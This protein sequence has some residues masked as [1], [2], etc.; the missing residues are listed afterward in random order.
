MLWRGF[1]C[2][3]AV[4]LLTALEPLRRTPLRIL[5]RVAAWSALTLGAVVSS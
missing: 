3:L 5:L 1:R 2:L 4:L